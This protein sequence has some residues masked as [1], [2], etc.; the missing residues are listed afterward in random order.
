MGCIENSFLKTKSRSAKHFVEY[1]KRIQIATYSRKPPKG[2]QA[3]ES[4]KALAEEYCMVLE[5][6]YTLVESFERKQK[7][8]R[9]A[10]E[11]ES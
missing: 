7:V 6:G 4:A 9:G 3:S 8:K 5:S 2:Q 10:T 11:K 1:S